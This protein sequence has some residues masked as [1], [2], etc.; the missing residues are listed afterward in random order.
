M[1]DS[2]DYSGGYDGG[3]GML[4]GV[5]PEQQVDVLHKV[6]SKLGDTWIGRLATSTLAPGRA[7]MGQYETTPATPGILT[8]EDVA[9]SQLNNRAMYDQAGDLGNLAV[10]GGIPK[11][12][13]EGV[14]GMSKSTFGSIAGAGHNGGPPMEP[15]AGANPGGF[16]SAAGKAVQGAP[17][18][19]PQ[20][21]EQWAAW[22]RNQP[23]VK[24]EELESL[25]LLPD[26]LN[27]ALP[28]R[29]DKQQLTGLVEGN[30][31]KF[32]PIVRGETPR[33]T[34]EEL[35]AARPRAFDVL[36]R[37]NIEPMV[38]PDEPNTLGFF[39]GNDILSHDDIVHGD[40]HP[41]EV[42]NAVAAIQRSFER[43]ND[44]GIPT[45]YDA[46]A[47]TRDGDSSIRDPN[48]R[49]TIYQLD[50]RPRDSVGPDDIAAE[51][52]KK[53]WDDVSAKITAQRERVEAARRANSTAFADEQ[54][55]LQQL[56]KVRDHI[57][58]RMVDDTFARKPY[59]QNRGMTADSDA[60]M[61][62]AQ[63][64]HENQSLPG[65]YPGPWD[66]MTATYRN[67]TYDQAREA[68]NPLPNVPYHYELPHFAAEQNGLYHLRHTEGR[69]GGWTPEKFA[70]VERR[71]VE[72]T[73]GK[74]DADPEYINEIG[75]M[76]YE[77]TL[78]PNPAT[79]DYAYWQELPE[80]EKQ[81]WRE[82]AINDLQQDYAGDLASGSPALAVRKGLITPEEAADFSRHMNW[83][84]EYA[85]EPGLP[86]L[87]S[88]H[89][90]EVQSDWLQRGRERGF[91]QPVKPIDTS[92]WR[93][94][95]ERN[96]EFT[97]QREVRVFDENGEMVG[98]RAG[99]SLSDAEIIR[100]FAQRREDQQNERAVPDAPFKTKWHEL[101]LKQAI[102]DAVK[103]GKDAVSWWP[104][105]VHA[106]RYGF[107]RHVS[108][109][110]YDPSAQ[111][112]KVLPRTGQR[113]G[114][115]Q[116]HNIAPD[117]L[118]EYVGPEIAEKLTQPLEGRG[119]EVDR[120][121][122]DYQKFLND[123]DLPQ[124]DV[125]ELIAEMNVHAYMTRKYGDPNDPFVQK[126][127]RLREFS[128]RFEAAG[129]VHRG[130]PYNSVKGDELKF[131][132]E[133]A[134]GMRG[135]YDTM[136][137][138]A[139][140]SLFKKYGAKVEQDTVT[141]PRGSANAH[142]LRITPKLRETVQNEG[143]PLF[144]AGVPLPSLLNGGRDDQ[145]P[146]N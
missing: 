5:T 70:D 134:K 27:P 114:S 81:K 57:H 102:L 117:R 79:G 62:R 36:A 34:E 85:S 124:R 28:E 49:E 22:L 133:R 99:T 55:N 64:G 98:H 31:P 101:A 38:N 16:Y 95:T 65:T 86:S 40:E 74:I 78:Q 51:K 25:G 26:K 91:Q 12:A 47:G 33:L 17:F 132:D 60:I 1:S 126:Y 112:L 24:P 32:N 69:V 145:Q 19:T 11:V 94:V 108:E 77:N 137:P 23:G 144:Q 110:R 9:R 50:R 128:R 43:G 21:A 54:W 41:N 142:I 72:A 45:Q 15:P 105:Q 116:T 61:Q 97:G 119:G 111:E 106:E 131:S 140:N 4:S 44:N 130:L 68:M 83:Q 29:L 127:D 48:Y 118:P 20:T 3:F 122:R 42:A 136:L 141:T 146:A 104:G 56:E 138:R 135:F 53:S 7:A 6:I 120:V 82:H 46:Y 123:N 71:I 52:Y 59:W 100:N 67:G 18:K 10:S 115:W 14:G 39:D 113:A 103:N 75:Q 96:N 139:A 8:D 76:R 35:R 63:E 90:E 92:K 87:N 73:H 37:H 13:L 109:M 143:L 89:L 66:E 88:H 2:F 93:A 129:D 107:D 121:T 30:T 58:S 125:D 80:A 84:N